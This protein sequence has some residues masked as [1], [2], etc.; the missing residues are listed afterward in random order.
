MSKQ[1]SYDDFKR[2]LSD[3]EKIIRLEDN[4]IRLSSDYSK[5][6]T[7]E[8]RL[9]FP[10]LVTN[11]IELLEVMLDDKDEWISY[12]IFELDFNKTGETTEVGID[13]KNYPLNSIKDLWELI[14]L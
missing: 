4:V 13:G 3:I 12:Y 8:F 14:H 5:K 10:T 7:E 6:S 11:A 1:I 9:S 2:H